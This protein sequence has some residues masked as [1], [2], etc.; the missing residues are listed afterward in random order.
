MKNYVHAHRDQA[1]SA[2]HITSDAWRLKLK[3]PTNDKAIPIQTVFFLQYFSTR[4]G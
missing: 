3:E 1:S 4:V 2:F